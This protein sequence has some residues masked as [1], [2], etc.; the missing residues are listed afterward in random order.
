VS[1]TARW[2]VLAGRFLELMPEH[3]RSNEERQ[4]FVQ[5]SVIILTLLAL[6]VVGVSRGRAPA[7]APR[8]R[9]PVSEL[10]SQSA[11]LELLQRD[12][13]HGH[14]PDRFVRQ[15]ARQ[16]ARDSAASFDGLTR[17]HPEQGLEAIHADAVQNGVAVRRAF[18]GFANAP[19]SSGDDARTMRNRLSTLERKL[20]E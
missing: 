14:L 4:A 16:L 13:T 15:H 20:R 18:A 1:G 19:A 11:E 9:I 7:D 5:L 10:R 8:L 17:L 3:H 2:T 6:L 12:A